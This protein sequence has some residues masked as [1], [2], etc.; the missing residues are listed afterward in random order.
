MRP[1]VMA[2]IQRGGQGGAGLSVFELIDVSGGQVLVAGG[3]HGIV[4]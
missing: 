3:H 1:V 2:W 4:R